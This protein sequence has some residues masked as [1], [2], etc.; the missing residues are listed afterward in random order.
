MLIGL[1]FEAEVFQ[2][3][4]NRTAKIKGWNVSDYDEYVAGLYKA[5]SNVLIEEHSIKVFLAQRLGDLVLWPCEVYWLVT[6]FMPRASRYYEERLN[7]KIVKE[8]G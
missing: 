7:S 2:Y 4:T 5:Y 8:E 1:I 3:L 6:W